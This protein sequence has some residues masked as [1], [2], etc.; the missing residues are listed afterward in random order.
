MK[1]LRRITEPEVIAEF[2]K[3]EYYQE[4]FHQDRG[5]FEALVLNADTTNDAENALRRA[6]LFRRRGHMWR[7]LPP[8]TQWWEMGLGPGDLEQVRVFPR[9]Q[10]RRVADGSFQI[11]AIV[12]RIRRNEFRGK[13]KAF[14]A[15][16]HALSYRL[17][18]HRDASTLMLIG[19]DESRPMTI[20][21]GNHRLT[22]AMLASEELALSCFRIVCGL[23][24]RMAESC[25]YE[26]NLP[27]LWRYAKNRFRNIVDKEADVDRV[28]TVTTNALTARATQ[29]TA[30]ESK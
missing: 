28:L 9:A 4:E 8:D 5:R 17:R 23:S 21:E 24:P 25:W 18:Q 16:L 29:S 11:G 6:L 19:V 7:E 10:W 14:V 2:L 30:P 12:R 13:D 22:A 3:N 27:N 1:K 26:T 20:L 15:K